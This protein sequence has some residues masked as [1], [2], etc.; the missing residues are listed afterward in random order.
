MT[1]IEQPSQTGIVNAAASHLGSTSRLQSIDDNI[2]LGLHARTAWPLVVRNAF[3][4]YPWTFNIVRTTLN[5]SASAPAFGYDFAYALPADCSRWLPPSH[6]DGDA[7]F[8]G[9]LENGQILTDA[10]APLRVRYISLAKATQVAR[11]PDYFVTAIEYSM[12]EALAEP[13]MQSA[14]LRR[15]MGDQA[16]ALWKTAKRRDA[17]SGG[18]RSRHQIASGSN[19]A[20]SRYRRFN[21]WGR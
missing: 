20:A 4:D 10:A 7:Y 16:L 3:G 21:P 14:S 5:A 11:W 1:M 19:W 9:V 15:D 13:L 6:E 8:E 17:Q 2:P 12:A 18:N